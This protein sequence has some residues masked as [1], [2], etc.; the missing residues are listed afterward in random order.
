MPATRA[1]EH[2]I[3]VTA[4]PDKVYELIADVANW[5]Q[6][7][8][9]TVH[10]EYVEREA[11][12]E[13]LR[14]WATANGAAKTW[15]SRR[16]LDRERL[17]IDFRQEVS[18]PPV[19]GMG[20]SWVV[21]AVPGTGAKVRL[22]HDFHPTSDDPADLLWIEQAVD[23]NSRAELAALRTSAEMDHGATDQLFTFDDTVRIDGSVKDVYDFLN[24]AR[25]WEDRLPHVDRVSLDEDTPGLQI[26]EMDTRAKDG[27]RHTTKSVRVCLP[28][29]K[30]VYK[31]IKVPPLLL[32]HTGQWL[33]TELPGGGVS[34][35][36][37]HTVR[38]NAANIG[39]ILGDGAGLADA[40]RF[41]RDAL[42]TN[43]RATLD[44]A[45]AF[46]ERR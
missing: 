44:H 28:Y 6:V 23:H 38:I 30:I 3:T 31:Q 12:S 35:T 40:R 22:S 14:I 7:F 42:G 25:L 34:V 36:S 33:L 45:K 19:G 20:G 9:P 29:H 18:P 39:R 2:E 8:S 21:E 1:V 37:R 43:S 4:P 41:V 11:T 27:S 16:E 10:V 24:E 5:P 32:L 15:L 46:A 13:R 26:L 17:R